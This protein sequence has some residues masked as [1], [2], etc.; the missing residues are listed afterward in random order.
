MGPERHTMK[1]S[2][3]QPNVERPNLERPASLRVI[4]PGRAGTS[5]ARALAEAGWRV[6]PPL[7]R[8]DDVRAAARDV[9]GEGVDLLVIATPDGAIGAVAAAVEPVERTVVAHLAGSIG[10]DVLAPHRRR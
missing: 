5:L 4:G 1:P 2:F 8:G 3:E 9:D 7:G 6:L 10:L